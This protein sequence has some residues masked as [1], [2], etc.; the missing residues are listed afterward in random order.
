MSD[1]FIDKDLYD[2]FINNRVNNSDVD[3]E[4]EDPTERAKTINTLFK[5][6]MGIYG[7]GFSNQYDNNV[8]RDVWFNALLV[9]S[10]E[11]IGDG[12]EL[13]LQD[14]EFKSIPNLKRFI[15]YCDE[16]K[17]GRNYFKDEQNKLEKGRLPKLKAESLK[18]HII[19]H[20]K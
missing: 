5:I 7:S 15:F 3:F 8:A 10:I 4:R 9:F 1:E 6:L 20:K 14:K 13:M 12:I 19:E 18:Q 17:K 16:A 2:R 11:N